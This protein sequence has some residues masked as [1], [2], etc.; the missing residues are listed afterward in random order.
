MV[1]AGIFSILGVAAE[2][3]GNA[4]AVSFVVA[5]LVA[6][7]STYSYA[8]LGAVFP[9]SGGAVT[10]LIHGFGAGTLSGGINIFMWV[11]YIFALALY[12]MAFG[13]YAATF[14]PDHGEAWT[15]ALALGIVLLFTGINFLGA[16]AV[17]K[18]ETIIV[19][20]KVAILMLFAVGG[21][22]SVSPER[23]SPSHWPPML[24][25]VS[26]CGL[27]FI[28]YEGFGLI[29]NAAGDMAD[30]KKLLP[31]AL[32]LTVAIVIVI[33]VGVAVVAIG[34]LSV[35][36]L[37]E[38]KEYALAAAA[39]PFLGMVG[40]K[41]IAIAAVL[42]TS[43]A[44]N[45]TLFGA[46]Q[47]SYIV[48]K[49]GQLPARFERGIWRKGTAGL[50]ITSALVIVLIMGFDLSAIAELGSAAFLLIYSGVN[51]AH[52][53]VRSQT[54][55]RAWIIWLA[56]A[57]CMAIFVSLVI[58]LARHYMVTLTTL[59]ATLVASFIAEMVMQRFRKPFST[60]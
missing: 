41:V 51:L 46:A 19:A 22:A 59:V 9:S 43:S 16:K 39:K 29:A 35:P 12:A 18:S 33:Y 57:S 42:S 47:V 25:I 14:V 28:G 5:G 32:Y 48:A 7:L 50:L 34:N 60:G 53:R 31:K 15:K 11:G 24:D 38:F 21:A 23:L 6:L 4:L 58:H 20:I 52:L 27:L 40:F 49:E 55:A 30:P 26:T 37:V 8:K 3:S 10:F 36:E 2:V 56:I 17:G 13:G 45:A 54:G 1:G 44:I